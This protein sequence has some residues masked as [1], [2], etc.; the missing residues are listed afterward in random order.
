MKT[1]LVTGNDTNIGKTFFTRRLVEQLIERGERVQVV[2]PIETGVMEAHD[3]PWVVAGLDPLRVSAHTLYTFQAPLAPVAAAEREREVLSFEDIVGKIKKLPDVDYRVIE[4][5]GGIAVPIAQ[6]G[7]DFRDLAMRLEVDELI[8][9]IENR[10]GAMNQAFLLEYYVKELKCEK[11]F[12]LNET[13]PQDESVK[14]TNIEALHKRSIPLTYRLEYQ[15]K[16]CYVD[17]C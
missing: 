7:E 13:R 11:H 5:A 1:I 17:A 14:K 16:E 6:T 12:C 8:L 10:L 9:V 15:E 3:A 4:S 2:K